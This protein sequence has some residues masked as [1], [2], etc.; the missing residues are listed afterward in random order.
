[1]SFDYAIWD[2]Y[3]SGYVTILAQEMA[4]YLKVERAGWDSIGWCKDMNEFMECHGFYGTDGSRIMSFIFDKFFGTS[5]YGTTAK[6]LEEKVRAI[7]E[8]QV[9]EAVNGIK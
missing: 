4:K 6:K 5:K 2:S 3:G 1:M 8:Q 7:V 9:A